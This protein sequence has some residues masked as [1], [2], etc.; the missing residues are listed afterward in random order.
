MSD[1]RY[2]AFQKAVWAYYAAQGR[3]DLPWRVP[4]MDRTFEPYKIMVSEYMLQQTQVPRVIPK[5]QAFLAAFPTTRALAAVPLGAVLIA[6]QGLGYNRR[7]KYLWQAAQ[8]IE[9]QWHGVFPR[10]VEQL[11]L[12]PGAGP[13]TA[14]AIAAYT[15]DE[16]VVFIETNIRSVYIHHF[17]ADQENVAD[18]AIRELVVQTLPTESGAYG[19]RSWYWA[20]MDYGTYLKQSVGNTARASRS[21]VRQAPFHRSRRQLR[22]KILRLLAQGP[23]L[24]RNLETALQDDRTALVLAELETEGLVQRQE[25]RYTLP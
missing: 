21:Y 5:Y 25:G 22:G 19:P 3:H 7:A 13:N 20:L 4:E 24:R 2:T 14:G 9:E 10:S 1:V 8:L 18:S 15:Y 12:L 11:Q 6:W 23:H 16:P 17:F